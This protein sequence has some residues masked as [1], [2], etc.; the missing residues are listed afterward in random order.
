ME[1]LFAFFCAD[2]VG[3]TPETASGGGWW[4]CVSSRNERIER[5]PPWLSSFF[6]LSYANPHPVRPIGS[7]QAGQEAVYGPSGVK[8]A[9]LGTDLRCGLV[10]SDP[11]LAVPTEPRFGPLWHYGW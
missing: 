7:V 2:A 3:G 4:M 5:N 9:L 8:M 6:P 1:V 11:Q 10:A